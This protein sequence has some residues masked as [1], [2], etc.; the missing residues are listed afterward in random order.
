MGG[1][2][3]SRCRLESL[4]RIEWTCQE[5]QFKTTSA[6]TTCYLA[7]LVGLTVTT[8]QELISILFLFFLLYLLFR[9]SARLLVS[10]HQLSRD[11]L[12]KYAFN[13]GLV[14]QSFLLGLFLNSV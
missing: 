7:L 3:E 14:F 4:P 12:M 8:E 9:I 5:A 2:T 1:L 6:S 10:I 11:V 13:K